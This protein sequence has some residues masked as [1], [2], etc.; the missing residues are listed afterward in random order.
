MFTVRPKE[1]SVT[2]D[3]VSRVDTRPRRRDVRLIH[4]AN[5]VCHGPNRVRRTTEVQHG[6]V[7]DEL[8]DPTAAGCCGMVND[9][10]QNESQTRPL[11]IAAPLGLARVSGEVDE[12]DGRRGGIGGGFDPHLLHPVSIIVIRFCTMAFSKCR[13]CNHATRAF[14]FGWSSPPTGMARSMTSLIGTPDVTSGSITWARKN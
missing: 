1:V 7:A 2:R 8:D 11:L 10:A 3:D 12:R 9:L 5:D 6:A 4:T 14:A 13:A